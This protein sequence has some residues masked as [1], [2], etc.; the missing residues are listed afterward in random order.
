MKISQ[1][2][3]SFPSFLIAV[4]FTHGALAIPASEKDLEIGRPAPLVGGSTGVIAPVSVPGQTLL[5]LRY[6]PVDAPAMPASRATIPAGDKVVVQIGTAPA[7]WPVQWAKNGRPL[8]GATTPFLTI[9][10]AGA[11]DAGVYV[12][13]LNVPSGTPVMTQAL[14]LGVGPP[15]RLVNLSNLATLPAGQGASVVTGFVVTGSGGTGKK[16]IIRAVGPSL[17]LFGFANALRHPVLRIRDGLGNLYE[18]AYVYPAVAGGLTYAADLAQSLASAGAFGTPAGS[19]DAVRLMP[20]PPGD[21][22]VQVTS[23][24]NTGGAVLFEIYE[25][26]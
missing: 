3:K 23:A 20:F 21:Y 5:Q 16:M 1:L 13:T 22:T 8:A 15:E 25:V 24:D 9:L 18:N 17:S 14:I 6:T 10:S 26:P 11:G 2:T 7:E 12:A 19:D 4:A